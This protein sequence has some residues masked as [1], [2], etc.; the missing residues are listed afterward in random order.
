MMV[1][2][3]FQEKKKDR[4]ERRLLVPPKNWNINE[5]R[6]TTSLERIQ[7]PGTDFVRL[8]PETGDG[9]GEGG[10]EKKT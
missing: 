7:P 8:Q 9:V 2:Q 10:K 1:G 6:H 5:E 4:R 3:N